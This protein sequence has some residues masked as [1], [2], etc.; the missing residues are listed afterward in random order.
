MAKLKTNIKSEL[1]TNGF[2]PQT[3]KGQI[4]QIPN[5]I[6]NKKSF[7]AKD[8]TEPTSTDFDSD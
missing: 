6:L 5:Y 3:V 2:Q 7:P 8:C 1:K 4:G